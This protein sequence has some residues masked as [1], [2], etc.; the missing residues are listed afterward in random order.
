MQRGQFSDDLEKGAGSPL[1]LGRWTDAVTHG[2]PD[3]T[4]ILYYG[5]TVASL[6]LQTRKTWYSKYS[7]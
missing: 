1:P 6:S 5:D 3:V 7:K 4:T 2:T